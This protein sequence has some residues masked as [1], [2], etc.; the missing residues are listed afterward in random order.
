MKPFAAIVFGAVG[1]AAIVWV[2][3]AI[4]DNTNKM[5]AV[6]ECAADR[7]QA[8]GYQ[9]PYSKEAAVLFSSSCR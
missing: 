8:E 9:D 6:L 3:L 1:F 7:A 4:E 5:F 2:N